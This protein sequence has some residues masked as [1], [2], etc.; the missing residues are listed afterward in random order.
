MTVL[1]S[2]SFIKLMFQHVIKKKKT[3]SRIYEVWVA[4]SVFMLKFNF[5]YRYYTC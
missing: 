3:A 5:E 2:Q 4:D 1:E